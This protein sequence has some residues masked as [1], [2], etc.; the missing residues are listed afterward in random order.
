MK[1]PPP[2]NTL[3]KEL[4][5]TQKLYL[6]ITPSFSNKMTVWES[7]FGGEPYFPKGLEYP[8]SPEGKPLILL[9]QINFSET[10]LLDNFPKEGILQFYIDSYHDLYGVDDEDLSNQSHFRVIYFDKIDLDKKN[11]ITDFSFLPSMDDPDMILPFIGSFA[12][13]FEQKSEPI[14]GYDYR[15]EEMIESLVDNSKEDLDY[16][17]LVEDYAD[18]Y[19]GEEHKLGGYP[20]F[21][22]DDPRLDFD[23]N[24]EAYELLFQMIS[25][26]DVD[27]M[28][29]DAGVGNFFIQPSALKKLDFSRVIYSYDCC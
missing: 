10:L 14:S 3:R 18:L 27:I 9:A 24:I 13:T 22:Q 5:P 7:K 2:L 28:W 16:Y 4:E 20:F 23:E 8:K 25:D 1:L 19:D 26:E 15:L 29:G 11:L 12:L 17:D 6:K 21:T